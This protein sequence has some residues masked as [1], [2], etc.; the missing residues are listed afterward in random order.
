MEELKPVTINVGAHDEDAPTDPPLEELP[1]EPTPQVVREAFKALVGIAQVL[2]H[3]AKMLGRAGLRQ[4]AARLD[5]V[6]TVQ[7]HAL[8]VVLNVAMQKATAEDPA[9]VTARIIGPG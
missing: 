8:A 2:R 3:E 4:A 9:A 1:T 7:E 6:A 5:K